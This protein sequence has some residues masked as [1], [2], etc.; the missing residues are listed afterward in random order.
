MHALLVI[1][2]THV[3]RD[4]SAG[5]L[6]PEPGH[7]DKVSSGSLY[8]TIDLTQDSFSHLEVCEFNR[9]LKRSR[10]QDED[11]NEVCEAEINQS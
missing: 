9:A 1:S 10:L 6:S 4:T 7:L 5:S 2:N 8:P 3:A 11:S